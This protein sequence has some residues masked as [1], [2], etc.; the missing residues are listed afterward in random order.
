MI[1]YFVNIFAF[2]ANEIFVCWYCFTL[3]F[4][5]EDMDLKF[6]WNWK[7]WILHLF[8]SNRKNQRS[9]FLPFT[10]TVKTW[11]I[12]E[13]VNTGGSHL[14]TLNYY[15]MKMMVRWLWKRYNITSNVIGQKKVMAHIY[16]IIIYSGH[17]VAH[18]LPI[19]G[20]PHISNAATYM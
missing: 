12:Q 5:R 9:Q 14:V 2:E 13:E 4:G 16:H 18:M 11:E 20:F 8:T 3:L 1:W 15:P 6:W 17:R 19:K 10:D 7:H